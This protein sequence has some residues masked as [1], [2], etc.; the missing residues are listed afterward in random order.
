MV[1]LNATNLYSL[2]RTLCNNNK[3]TTQQ[4]GM[5]NNRKQTTMVNNMEQ[6]MEQTT[7][8][9][10]TMTLLL[11]VVSYGTT[12]YIL[13]KEGFPR[14]TPRPLYPGPVIPLRKQE[15]LW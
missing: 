6:T 14:C 4:K 9:A 11:L 1:M 13:L 7:T 5:Y 10:T 12:K 2:F 3:K 8:S 15:Q